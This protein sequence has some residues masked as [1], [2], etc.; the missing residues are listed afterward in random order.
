MDICIK[1]ESLEELTGLVSLIRSEPLTPEQLAALTARM[2][3]ADEQ[4]QI[5]LDRAKGAVTP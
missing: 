2:K 5:A 3:T 1:I 4:A